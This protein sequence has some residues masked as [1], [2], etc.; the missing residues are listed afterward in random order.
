MELAPTPANIKT[1]NRSKAWVSWS[2]AILLA[3]ISVRHNFLSELGADLDGAWMAVL[4]LALARHW[5]FGRDVIFT[6]GPLAFLDTGVLNHPGIFWQFLA[7]ALCVF[8]IARLL[9]VGMPRRLLHALAFSCAVLPAVIAFRWCHFAQVSCMLAFLYSGKLLLDARPSLLDYA[10]CAFFSTTVFFVKLNFGIIT[11]MVALAASVVLFALRT[12]R[13]WMLPALIACF[14][15]TIVLVVHIDLVGYVRYGLS[16]IS[17]YDEAM[18]LTIDT[19]SR[20]FR[21]A[22]MLAGIF[23]LVGAIAIFLSFRTRQRLAGTTA[24]AMLSL[25]FFYLCFKNSFIRFDNTHMRQLFAATPLFLVLAIVV[26]GYSTRWV[27]LLV[28]VPVGFLAIRILPGFNEPLRQLSMHAMWE[29]ANTAN[30]Y[31]QLF[32]GLPDN[33]IRQAA[34]WR[35]GSVV[36]PPGSD[37]SRAVMPAT[38]RQQIGSATVD[39]IPHD[40]QYLLFSGCNYVPR[41]IIQSYQAY[42]PA[43]DSANMRHFAGTHRPR[44]LLLSNAGI[45]DRCYT[46][47]ES[48]TKAAVQLNYRFM[49][50]VFVDA[51]QPGKS[52]LLAEDNNSKL[53]PVMA[54]ISTVKAHMGDR[55]AVPA[56]SLPVYM[57]V[58]VNYTASGKLRKLLFQPGRVNIVQNTKDEKLFHRLVLP[59]ARSP[60]L[61]NYTC[62]NN[63]ELLHFITGHISSNKPVTSVEINTDAPYVAKDISISFY[64]FANYRK[65]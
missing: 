31:R 1:G 26:S 42:A 53:L 21:R 10:L 39:I 12:H 24:L 23:A 50:T 36:I 17:N 28:I 2:L 45:D 3:L 41:P 54:L 29:R 13:A 7:D 64:R 22:I 5:V 9:V 37:L 6:Y 34:Q 19:G 33:S 52:L 46:W 44:L 8:A 32:S 35:P 20:P 51:S 61:I 62:V 14:F 60:M 30:Y 63:E 25:L 56:D 18:F 11:L 38:T 58:A 48:L 55:I 40:I 59:I 65:D 27:A 15:M 16:I 57:T 49:D 47:D 43:L 4:D